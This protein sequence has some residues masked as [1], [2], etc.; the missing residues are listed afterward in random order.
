MSQNTYYNN[1]TFIPTNNNFKNI[2]FKYKLFS[3]FYKD[4]FSR[5]PESDSLYRRRNRLLVLF[6]SLFLYIKTCNNIFNRFEVDAYFAKKISKFSIPLAKSLYFFSI[7]FA[8]Q[9][10]LKYVYYLNKVFKSY[11]F[12]LE[13]LLKYNVIENNYSYKGD[14]ILTGNFDICDCENIKKNA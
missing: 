3:S 9:L 14:S 12:A 2:L 10:F 8:S 6:S 4:Y 7:I 5:T 11:Q 1:K 13:G